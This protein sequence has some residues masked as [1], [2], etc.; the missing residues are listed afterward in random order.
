MIEKFNHLR[1]IQ[2]MMILA[3]LLLLFVL[4]TQTS[5]IGQILCDGRVP[6]IL[7]TEG[8]DVIIGT[9]GPDVIHG[10]GTSDFIRGMGGD[11][12]IC[13]GDGADFLSGVGGNDSLY[14][15]DGTDELK[16]GWG[17]ENNDSC[18]DETGT[19]ITGCEQFNGDYIPPAPVPKTGE[20]SDE[21]G[22][23][24]PDPRFTDKCCRF[25]KRQRVPP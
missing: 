12:V 6:T 4:T 11:D 21:W 20:D 24:W 1:P 15:G 22:V 8:H 19:L 14:G 16:G 3:L 13:G 25:F 23:D 5:A 18:Y 17:S 10:L 7:G 2:N 9:E